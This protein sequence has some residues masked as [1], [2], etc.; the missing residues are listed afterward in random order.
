M[1]LSNF[2]V[3]TYYKLQT[4]FQENLNGGFEVNQRSFLR[5]DRQNSHKA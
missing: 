1:K 3:L 4:K 2:V 5:Q